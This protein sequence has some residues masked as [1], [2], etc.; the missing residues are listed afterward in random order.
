MTRYILVIEPLNAVAT[1]CGTLN[2]SVLHAGST[3]LKGAWKVQTLIFT[4]G[5]KGLIAMVVDQ[6]EL[7]EVGR[8]LAAAGARG[9]LPDLPLADPDRVLPR[10]GGGILSL[11]RGRL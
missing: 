8:L 5:G 4:S 9:G 10:A 7:N 11:R 6:V 3:G 2:I 1:M